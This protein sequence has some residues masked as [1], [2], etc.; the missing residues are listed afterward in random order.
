MRLTTSGLVDGEKK[1]VSAIMYLV[2]VPILGY[3]IYF[4]I[5]IA[6][7]FSQ[8][9]SLWL[10]LIYTS[11]FFKGIKGLAIAVFMSFV[12]S[13]GMLV[14]FYVP[15]LVP[16][17]RVAA[18][19]VV[20]DSNNVV[21]TQIYFY[22]LALIFSALIVFKGLWNT[23]PKLDVS[24]AV[25]S[26]TC[27][28]VL[29]FV[30]QRAFNLDAIKLSF[31]M[32]VIYLGVFSVVNWSDQVFKIGVGLLRHKHKRDLVNDDSPNK[33]VAGQSNIQSN[34]VAAFKKPVPVAGAFSG[35]AA[36]VPAE[37][38][39][40]DQI[41]DLTDHDVSAPIED[42]A[43]SSGSN[44]IPVKPDVVNRAFAIPMDE[45]I[46]IGDI[47]LTDDD[48]SQF[49]VAAGPVKMVAVY[50]DVPGAYS[51]EFVNKLRDEES[52]EEEES[53]DEEISNSDGKYYEKDKSV[54]SVNN[55]H[56]AMTK[57]QLDEASELLKNGLRT[58]ISEGDV[59]EIDNLVDEIMSAQSDVI[60]NCG[61]D[62][63]FVELHKMKVNGLERIGFVKYLTK[64]AQE[65]ASN[66]VEVD[67]LVVEDVYEEP[68]TSNVAQDRK[69]VSLQPAKTVASASHSASTLVDA[70]EE[71]VRPTQWAEIAQLITNFKNKPIDIADFKEKTKHR[72]ISERSNSSGFKILG[73]LSSLAE[74][75]NSKEKHEDLS[76]FVVMMNGS[77]IKDIQSE[78]AL[79][80]R[81]F[82]AKEIEDEI[83]EKVGADIRSNLIDRFALYCVWADSCTAIGQ[84][85]FFVRNGVKTERDYHGAKDLAKFL[86]QIFAVYK[87][88][89]KDFDD[90]NLYTTFRDALALGERQFAMLTHGSSRNIGEIDDVQASEKGVAT[91][92]LFNLEHNVKWLFDGIERL[93][94]A[95]QSVDIEIAEDIRHKLS[96]GLAA[97]KR[98][99]HRLFE[100][101][102]RLRKEAQ[103]LISALEREYPNK[104]NRETILRGMSSTLLNLYRHVSSDN[105]FLRNWKGREGQLEEQLNEL[106]S[107]VERVTSDRAESIEKLTADLD[108]ANGRLAE[109]EIDRSAT[110]FRGL[111][112]KFGK[113][114]LNAFGADGGLAR[115]WF[116]SG[117]D[118]DVYVFAFIHGMGLKWNI[119]NE[120]SLMNES[121]GISYDLKEIAQR[122]AALDDLRDKTRAK[123]RFILCQSSGLTGRGNGII[124]REQAFSGDD[125][126]NVFSGILSVDSQDTDIGI[127]TE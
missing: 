60:K 118:G 72:T 112:E 107:E 103:N 16:K 119:S 101:S 78:D 95:Y 2:T 93:L 62:P 12:L 89:V 38:V 28:L 100:I 77:D 79:F 36:S 67:E 53:F 74:F 88:H 8:N 97:D 98:E 90:R 94:M 80:M 63:V 126:E 66:I 84:A 19:Y 82:L 52:E 81:Q 5:G 110:I 105:D 50:E 127:G 24:F 29:S 18:S 40:D 65:A 91:A 73:F 55:I 71:I 113:M 68:D 48:S 10:L 47:D 61:D 85:S 3:G 1:L 11:I 86:D 30:E 25:A 54:L 15:I 23:S 4:F 96:V 87:D 116:E 56:I 125:I 20:N 120:A 27:L 83:L 123:V 21:G 44:V 51:N 33:E 17:L 32:T 99:D 34:A 31:A 104:I 109:G 115:Y 121:V 7:V 108:V 70:D 41:E 22:V 111:Y 26:S 49:S 117:N 92:L 57:E 124:Y 39:T 106:K 102:V 37:D 35:G 6:D 75:D 64:I 9:L 122:I 42:E 58:I 14:I 43:P 69:V 114:E 45:D 46:E 76:S 59:D 13:F